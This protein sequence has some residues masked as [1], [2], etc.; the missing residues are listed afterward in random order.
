[1]SLEDK[2]DE[3]NNTLLALIGTLQ[4]QRPVLPA[5]STGKPTD[6]PEAEPE[7]EPEEA[8]TSEIESTTQA[9]KP[10]AETVKA[11]FMEL[12]G[13][14][15]KGRPAMEKILAKVGANKLSD[16]PASKYSAVLKAIEKEKQA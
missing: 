1:M 12:V 15:G 16:I 8:D 5:Q 7:V 14:T 11:A 13:M 3:L 9:D 10:T 6:A 2:I 4:A